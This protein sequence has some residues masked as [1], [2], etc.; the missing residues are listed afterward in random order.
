VLP[1]HNKEFGRKKRYFVETRVSN[2]NEEVF[3][4][5]IP[6]ELIYGIQIGVEC[7]YNKGLELVGK[8]ITIDELFLALNKLKKLKF[9]HKILLSFII[10][11]PWETIYEIQQT[12]DTVKQITSEFD[13]LC[14]ISWLAFLPSRLWNERDKYGIRVNEADYDAIDWHRNEVFFFTSHP[15]IDMEAL[16][17]VAGWYKDMT[18]QNKRIVYNQPF[19]PRI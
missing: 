16:S 11:F 2:V 7:G 15:R 10:G 1:H 3:F 5:S 9:T 8:G 12:L 13:V 18:Y 19:K 6:S 14:S 17:V 4:E